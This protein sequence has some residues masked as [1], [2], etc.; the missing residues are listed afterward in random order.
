[1]NSSCQSRFTV[2]TAA[3]RDA[4][5]ETTT[6]ELYAYGAAVQVFWT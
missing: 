4:C 2:G 3:G 6:V 1:M 5:L